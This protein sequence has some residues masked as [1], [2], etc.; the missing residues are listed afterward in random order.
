MRVTPS[1]KLL[2]AMGK[3][4]HCAEKSN[5]SL[6]KNYPQ[7]D[8]IMWCTISKLVVSFVNLTLSLNF[9]Y[10]LWAII[11]GSNEKTLSNALTWTN[12]TTN[13][14]TTFFPSYYT[15]S[16]YKDYSY[17]SNLFFTTSVQFYIY[18]ITW[19]RSRYL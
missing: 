6:Y 8:S 1:F 12:L 3:F 19:V 10:A 7:K 2:R 18:G 17:N 14:S 13:R 5:Q 4:T 16:I 11:D 9:C 15:K